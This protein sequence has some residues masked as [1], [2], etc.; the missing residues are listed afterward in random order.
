MVHWIVSHC[1]DAS[2][3]VEQLAALLAEALNMN[4]GWLGK[5]PGRSRL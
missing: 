1:A 2:L 5:R 3:I 4:W